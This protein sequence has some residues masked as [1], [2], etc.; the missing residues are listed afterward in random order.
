MTAPNAAPTAGLTRPTERPTAPEAKGNIKQ[1]ST[2]S[3][4]PVSP[5]P[6]S[7]FRGL[8][9]LAGRFPPGRPTVPPRPT[10][11]Q[12]APTVIPAK[13]GIHNPAAMVCIRIG[14]V[15]MACAEHIPTAPYSFRPPHRHSR[16]SGNPYPRR[17]SLHRDWPAGIADAAHILPRPIVIPPASPR[18]S[19]ESGNPH[20]CR[21]SL[22][23]DLPAGIADA[24]HIPPRPIVIPLA[25]TVIPAK[26]GIHT[27]AG[28]VCTG[29]CRVV[30]RMRRIFRP[31][32]P[33]FR[34]STTPP[35]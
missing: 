20:P 22:P 21:N 25:P 6:A 13:A 1:N 12:P 34:E 11:I 18:H 30:W 9:G 35:E 24:A 26:A 33:S 3:R 27:P 4:H 16:E 5:P 14:R 31:A 28:M 10:V 15:S 2:I 32:L 7:P 17:N 23:R 29:N 8:A 19:R